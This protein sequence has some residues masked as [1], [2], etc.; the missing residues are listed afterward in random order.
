[1]LDISQ[2]VWGQTL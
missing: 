1:M 2:L